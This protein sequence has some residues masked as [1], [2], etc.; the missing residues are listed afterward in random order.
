MWFLYSPVGCEMQTPPSHRLIQCLYAK[1]SVF[2][3]VSLSAELLCDRDGGWT[4]RVGADRHSVMNINRL[5]SSGLASR[6][7]AW[8][9]VGKWSVPHTLYSVFYLLPHLLQCTKHTLTY[10]SLLL[11]VCPVVFKASLQAKQLLLILLVTLIFITV[12]SIQTLFHG[13]ESSESIR[14]A[15]LFLAGKIIYCLFVFYLESY[16]N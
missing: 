15:S 10:F 6:K 14:V 5:S 16:R 1:E 12:L 7:Q 2:W 13:K 4:D 3:F 11:V 8:D 9:S